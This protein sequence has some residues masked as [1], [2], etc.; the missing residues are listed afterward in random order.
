M[1]AIDRL[2]IPDFKTIDKV[3][4]IEAKQSKLDNNIPVYTINAGTQGI[5]RIE[6]IFTAG[7]KQQQKPVV[8]AAVNSMIVE[9]TSKHTAAQIA[10][11]IDYY[12]AFFE[13][14][15]S[16]DNAILTIYSLNKH[17]L[18]TLPIIEQVLKD[19]SFPEHEV[20]TYV[21]NRKSKYIV[22]SKKVSSVARKKFAELIFGSQHSYGYNV[23]LE[24][25]DKL[26]REDISSFY[27]SFYG[28]NNCKIVVSGKVDDNV[29]T[30]LNKHFG[31]NN[32]KTDSG[33][34]SYNSPAFNT[35]SKQKNIVQW[36]DAIQS[37]LRIGKTMFNK[38]HPDYAPMQLLNCALGGYFGSRLMSNIREDKG[39]TYGIGSGLVSMQDTGY[40][41][42]STEVGVDVREKA[43][44]EIYKEIKTI[45][46]NL[47]SENELELVRNYMLGT[48]LRSASGPFALADKFKSIMDYGLDYTYYDKYL[49]SIR[50]TTPEQLLELAKKYLQEES[51]IELVVG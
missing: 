43:L 34:S 14:E 27:K 40:F 25:Y 13:T 51:L 22:S 45:R 8:A 39:Y 7:I 47:I 5:V 21:R 4:L 17:L 24:D 32:W 20:E 33:A 30:A 31:D 37:A 16:Q 10:D 44:T 36:E 38:T 46:E 28:S 23:Q 50:H 19:A 41:F 15:I 48:F 3:E 6:F 26:T 18:K 35:T 2:T 11:M 1:V 9:G 29:L 49:D 12:G 42:I